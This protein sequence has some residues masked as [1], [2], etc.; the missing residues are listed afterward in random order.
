MDEN[1]TKQ[2]WYSYTFT[3]ILPVKLNTNTFEHCST[4]FTQ[5]QLM[6]LFHFQHFKGGSVIEGTVM[7]RA[8]GFFE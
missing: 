2:I 7:R 8:L 4:D 5:V 6:K 1:K 3:N